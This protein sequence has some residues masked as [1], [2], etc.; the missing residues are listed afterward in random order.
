MTREKWLET[1]EKIRKQFQIDH[2]EHGPWGEETPG[3]KWLVEFE[4]PG[5]GKIKMEWVEKPR[6]KEVKTTYANRIGSTTKVTNVYD[7][8][9]MVNYL[10][11]FKWN[12]REQAWEKLANEFMNL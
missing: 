2:E 11:V 12:E 7:E 8:N 10:N 4:A 5:M 3:E 6:L 1:L 9:E